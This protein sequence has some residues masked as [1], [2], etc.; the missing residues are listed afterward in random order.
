MNTIPSAE[1][2]QNIAAMQHQQQT[3]RPSSPEW[4]YASRQLSAFYAEM[5][6]REVAA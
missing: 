5:A 6:N 4:Q 2:L 1:I 3:N